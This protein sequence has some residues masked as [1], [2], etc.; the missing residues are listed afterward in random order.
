VVVVNSR[1]VSVGQGLIVLCAAENAK[2]GKPVAEI[3]AAL[4]RAIAHTRTYGVVPDL[5]YAVRGG[6][7]PRQWRWLARAL[8]LGFLLA[9][10]DRGGVKVRGV[11]PR[12]RDGVS[13]LIRVAAR[14]RRLKSGTTPLRLAIA[15][16]DSPD[17]AEALRG[18]CVAAFPCLESIHVADLG[19]AYGVHAGPGTLALAIQE[20]EPPT[21]ES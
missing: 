13:A 4:D 8:P 2:A 9:T 11:L 18:A 1:N 12:G 6:R 21:R 17:S 5:S 16:A 14:D 19:P 20:Y 15:H 10:D 3:L 7:I